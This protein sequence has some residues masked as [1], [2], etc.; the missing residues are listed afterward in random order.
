[1]VVGSSPT[2]TG[3]CFWRVGRGFRPPCLRLDGGRELQI[4]E[5]SGYET[6]HFVDSLEMLHLVNWGRFV[7]QTLSLSSKARW[8]LWALTSGMEVVS[9]KL[10]LSMW[11]GHSVNPSFFD[12]KQENWPLIMWN[13]TRLLAFNVGLR[14]NCLLVSLRESLSSVSWSF[15]GPSL[16]QK[17][18]SWRISFSLSISLSK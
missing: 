18:N 11:R 9:T 6:C 13:S 1:M 12:I 7:D 3:S 4:Q 14:L 2:R 10:L 15:T 5:K 17:S 16:R 8:S